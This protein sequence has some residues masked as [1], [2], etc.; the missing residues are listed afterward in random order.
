MLVFYEH[1]LSWRIVTLPFFLLIAMS[2]GMGVGMWFAPLQV[3]F[4]DMGQVVGYIS[5][6][7]YYMTPVIYPRSALPQPLDQIILFNPITTVV[8]GFRWALVDGQPPSVPMLVL[9]MVISFG[10]LLTGAL[11]FRRHEATFADL[12]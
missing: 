9:S 12:A 5:R 1:P 11:Y 6:I 10:L 4:R 8:E 2:T 7:W 3:R